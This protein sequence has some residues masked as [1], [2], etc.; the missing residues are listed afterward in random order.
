MAT[1]DR[2]YDIAKETTSQQ[3]L[4]GIG[5]NYTSTITGR[6]TS[7]NSSKDSPITIEGSGRIAFWSTGTGY[8][9][10]YFILD[11]ESTEYSN[12]VNVAYGACVEIYFNTKIRFYNT[13][14]NEAHYIAQTK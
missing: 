9:R 10:I 3:I 6:A 13:E 5:N 11:D 1:G 12:S 2:N 4:E 7:N 8:G 14:T